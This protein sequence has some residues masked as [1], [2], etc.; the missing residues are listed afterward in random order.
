MSL[1]IVMTAH[2]LRTAVTMLQMTDHIC[3]S[4]PG[5]SAVIATIVVVTVE[6]VC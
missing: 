6:L 2:A 4:W 3:D 1:L 5:C